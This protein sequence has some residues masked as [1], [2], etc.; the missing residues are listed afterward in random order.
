MGRDSVDLDMETFPIK[1]LHLILR[2]LCAGDIQ[3]FCLSSQ[4]YAQML[5]DPFFANSYA[6]HRFRLD[7]RS[8][9]GNRWV[10]IFDLEWFMYHTENF[11]IEIPDGDWDPFDNPEDDRNIINPD[12]GEFACTLVYHGFPDLAEKVFEKL[13]SNLYWDH[14]IGDIHWLKDAFDNISYTNMSPEK[15]IQF[16]NVFLKYYVPEE[17]VS[18]LEQAPHLIPAEIEK[19]P[20]L[21]WILLSRHRLSEEFC[22]PLREILPKT[23]RYHQQAPLEYWKSR[24]ALVSC[25]CSRRQDLIEYYQT[26][27][28]ELDGLI[29]V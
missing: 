1:I 19:H 22:K 27:I 21:A 8:C 18:L 24:V 26:R 6:L 25:Y 4:K 5:E 2:E 16:K 9:P 10:R 14:D 7:I 13:F 20:E 23:Y 11:K 29:C 12:I 28:R 3:A 17:L 15:K